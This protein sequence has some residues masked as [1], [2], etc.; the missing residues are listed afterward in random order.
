M[1]HAF[2]GQRTGGKAQTYSYSVPNL[3][4]DQAQKLAQATA[5]DITRHERILTAS[6]PGDNL[7]TTRCMIDLIGTGTAWDQK[8]YPDTVTRRLSFEEGYR[9]EVR[10][11]NHSTQSTVALG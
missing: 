4:R 10:A 7:L 5:E 2:N 1:T 6:L 9:M 11:K 8:Y 3:S